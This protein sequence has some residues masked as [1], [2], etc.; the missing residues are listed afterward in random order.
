MKEVAVVL[1]SDDLR[2][3]DNPALFYAVS[4]GYQILP[5]FIYN[6]NYL[7]RE[8]GEAS[9]VFLH[10]IL[11]SFNLEL[12]HNLTIKKGDV[13]E[14]LSQIQQEVG[15]KKIFFNRSYVK[16][17]IDA[18]EKIAKHFSHQ[19]FKAKLI[20]EPSE[21]RQIKVFTP[22]WKE[23]LSKIDTISKP[24][25]APKELDF[26]KI[27]SLKLAELNLLPKINWWQKCLSH[28]SFSYQEISQKVNNF[29][30][31]K[32]HLYAEK[33]NNLHEDG[34]SYFSP[35]IRFG[36]LSPRIL[37][38][39]GYEKST[40]FTSELGWREFAFHTLFYNQDLWRKELKPEYQAFEWDDNE[41]I[42]KKWQKGE[43]GE[44][45]IDA[46]MN[47]LWETGFMHNRARMI[48]ASFLI[49]DLLTNWRKG[50]EWFWNCLF[51]ACP[52]VNPFSWQWVFG[53][54]YDASPYFRVFNPKLQQ[55]KFDPQRVYVKKWLK[56]ASFPIVDHEVQR[57]IC[58]ERYKK[59]K[60]LS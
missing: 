2:L 9:K 47:E 40:I 33:R 52:A 56:K 5:L 16:T 20:F 22:F 17:Q 50:E 59:V 8:L 36:V 11:K 18:E 3:E 43:T 48:S 39:K 24:L 57:K 55:E 32:S 27:S 6:A 30:D 4:Q 15:F 58:L 21:V 29:F 60:T 28:W 42:L 7:G 44:E 19:S 1:F 23:C 31:K 10:N 53:S 14:V 34:V 25:P 38:W 26:I 12:N 49:K 13:I 37:F 35:Y 46:S 51:D 54:G 45:I 41:N